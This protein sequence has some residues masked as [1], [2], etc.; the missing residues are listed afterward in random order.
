MKYNSYVGAPILINNILAYLVGNFLGTSELQGSL[1]DFIKFFYLY[2]AS[3]VTEL[4]CGNSRLALSIW[5]I[6]INP[7]L[8]MDIT[9]KILRYK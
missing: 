9:I 4:Q 2:C 5:L 6:F 3:K 1:F 8:F 7:L